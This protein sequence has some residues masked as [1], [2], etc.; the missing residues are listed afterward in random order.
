MNKIE[1]WDQFIEISKH[2][3]GAEKIYRGQSDSSWHLTPSLTRLLNKYEVSRNKAIQIELELLKDFQNNNSNQKISK[4]NP[5]NHILWWSV[6]QHFG[7]PTRLL[8]WTTDINIAL[9]FAVCN[10][11]DKDGALF[12]FDDGHLN[13]IRHNRKNAESANIDLQLAK[14]MDGNEYE[15]SI[16]AFTM[17]CL[18]I[19]SKIKKVVLLFQLS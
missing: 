1:S 3:K 8:D 6:M 10:N 5:D 9:Y 18:L 15:A 17:I 16:Y 12:L 7:A 4:F 2:F 13:F 14:S 11:F 19:E